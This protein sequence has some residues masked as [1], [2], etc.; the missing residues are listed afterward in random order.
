MGAVFTI[1]NS[2]ISIHN[3]VMRSFAVRRR[4]IAGLA[5]ASVLC[6]LAAAAGCSRLAGQNSGPERDAWQHP[7]RV[8]DALG[9]KSGSVVAD[10]G[11]GRGYFTFKLAERVGP[12]GKVYA[13][14]LK[15]DEL[16]EIREK[17]KKQGLTQI[18]TISGAPDDPKLPAAT[19]DVAM[20]VDSYH[21]M[22][23][24]DAILASIFRAL[25]P[26]GRLA[27]IDGVPQP[28]QPGQTGQTAKSREDYASIHRMPQEIERADAARNGFNFVREEPGFKRPEPK[29]DYYFLIF[30]KPL[31]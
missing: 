4:A 9:V 29:K 24:Y 3:S 31:L 27:M 8:L 16:A 12:Q 13:E 25:K 26:G 21:E 19:L 17:A 15:E 14:D 11:C 6:W 5:V 28:G 30:E 20:L 2:E 23:D 7:D 10:V 1:P 22:H 18:E